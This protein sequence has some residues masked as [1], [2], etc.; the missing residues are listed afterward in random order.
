MPSAQLVVA[1]PP[2]L[3]WINVGTL[4]LGALAER[5]D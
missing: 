2:L 3:I 1:G 5:F 4:E